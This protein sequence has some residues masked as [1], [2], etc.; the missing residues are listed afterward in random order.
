L[1]PGTAL[2]RELKAYAGNRICGY[3][4]SKNWQMFGVLIQKDGFYDSASSRRIKEEACHIIAE[5]MPGSQK[6]HV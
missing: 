4:S 2:S 5:D 1:L 3:N 6:G